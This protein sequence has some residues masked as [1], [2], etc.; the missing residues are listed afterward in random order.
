MHT[1]SSCEFSGDRWQLVQHSC[2]WGSRAGRG[3]GGAVL[4]GE[5]A[6]ALSQRAEAPRTLIV[7]P[8]LPDFSQEAENVGVCVKFTNM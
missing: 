8:E 3:G 4:N 1:A 7:G 6:C 5:S 2:V